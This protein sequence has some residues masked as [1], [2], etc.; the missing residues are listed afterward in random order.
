MRL[1]AKEKKI[2]QHSDY[3]KLRIKE[4]GSLAMWVFIFHNHQAQLV[5]LR[6]LFWR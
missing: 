5:E 6:M 2:T 3:E 4:I 1:R